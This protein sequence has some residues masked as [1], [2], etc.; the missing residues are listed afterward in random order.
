MYIPAAF[1]K[2]NRLYIAATI[3]KGQ[4]NRGI[5]GKVKREREKGEKWCK[6]YIHIENSKKSI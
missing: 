2:F 6:Y 3:T 1:I 4:G 5:R